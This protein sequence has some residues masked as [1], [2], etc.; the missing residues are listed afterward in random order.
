MFVKSI[1]SLVVLFL[2]TFDCFLHCADDFHHHLETFSPSFFL[3]SGTSSVWLNPCSLSAV[4][5][6]CNYFSARTNQSVATLTK[7]DAQHELFHLDSS[8]RILRRIRLHCWNNQTTDRS[9]HKLFRLS[10]LALLFLSKALGSHPWL[11]FFLHVHLARVSS[12][13]DV[14]ATLVC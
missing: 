11:F 10:L 2:K 13:R 8:H 12:S 3:T 5:A 7:A 14:F 1:T 6:C 4:P 9:G